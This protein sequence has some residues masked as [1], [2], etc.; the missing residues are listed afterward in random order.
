MLVNQFKY[1]TYQKGPG[2]I[3]ETMAGMIDDGED[4]ETAA[5]REILEETGYSPRRL[6]HISTFYLSPGGTS[7]RIVLYYAEV[8][9]RKTS[10]GGGLAEEGE[11]I[12]NVE[13]SVEDA[14]AQV[15]SGEIADAK[16]IIAILWLKDRLAGGNIA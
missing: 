14:L 10:M 3:T 16:T 2:W 5:R 8:D 11:D 1:P 7:E 13:L 4:P 9:D 15:S 12:V 6:E